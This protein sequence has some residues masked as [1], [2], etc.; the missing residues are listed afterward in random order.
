[1]VLKDFKFPKNRHM[2]NTIPELLEEAR[3]R[4]FVDDHGP[5]VRLF[6]NLFFNGGE[7]QPKP[8]IDQAYYDRMWRY[9]RGYMGSFIAK[10]ESK[11]A[12]CAML[13]SEIV[14]PTLAG[15]K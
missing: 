2:Y 15:K 14:L 5:Y 8:D 3:I 11:E 10:H 7:V 13:L 12:I 9:I 6:S 4:G 1:M